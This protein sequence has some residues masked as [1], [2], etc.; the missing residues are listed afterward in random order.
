M[1]LDVGRK[2]VV[3]DAQGRLKPIGDGFVVVRGLPA[4]P[5]V[6]VAKGWFRSGGA[7]ASNHASSL[8]PVHKNTKARTYIM[9][10]V[11][12]GFFGARHRIGLGSVGS[13]QTGQQRT[14]G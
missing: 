7:A 10:R 9:G 2:R 8:S 14:F 6:C 3:I 5:L 13:L 1:D 4:T 11:G 12:V